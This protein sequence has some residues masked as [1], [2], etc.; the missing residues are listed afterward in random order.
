M[1]LVCL[2]ANQH[3]TLTWKDTI[4]VFSVSQGNVEALIRWG[5]KYSNVI[6]CV[7]S[8]ISAKYYKNLSML[9]GVIAKNVGDVFLRHSVVLVVSAW[10]HY[11]YTGRDWCTGCIAEFR[12]ALRTH[13]FGHWQLQCW[14][15]MFFMCCAS[16]LTYSTSSILI[17]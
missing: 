15:T 4:S 16:L 13:L 17:V 1:Q 7:F 8:N 3:A 9:S 5:G 6:A 11:R 10:L 12:R 14:V 2:L